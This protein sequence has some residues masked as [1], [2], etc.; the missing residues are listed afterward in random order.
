VGQRTHTLNGSQLLAPPFSAIVAAR[1]AVHSLVH[2]WDPPPPSAGRPAIGLSPGCQVCQAYQELSGS[3]QVDVRRCQVSPCQVVVRSFR[4]GGCASPFRPV[5]CWQACQV[6]QLSG[7]VRCCQACQVLSGLSG[8][9]GQGWGTTTSAPP[10]LSPGSTL[11]SQ[12]S[13]KPS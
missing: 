7:A 6:C 8:L 2:G 5:R 9:S 12:A 13:V 1:S 3:C 4:L 10:H 11:L